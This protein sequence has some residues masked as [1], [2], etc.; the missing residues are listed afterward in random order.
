[1]LC[2]FSSFE[3]FHSCIQQI[4]QS[5]QQSPQ[6]LS[7]LFVFHV[8]ASPEQ[9]AD[10][11]DSSA[12]SRESNCLYGFGIQESKIQVLSDWKTLDDLK[13]DFPTIAADIIEKLWS[14]QNSSGQS[15]FQMLSSLL[16][17]KGRIIINSDCNFT[18]EEDDWP[19]LLS[20]DLGNDVRR[21]STGGEQWMVVTMDSFLRDS[22]QTFNNSTLSDWQLIKQNLPSEGRSYRDILLS[23]LPTPEKPSNPLSTPPNPVTVDWKAKIL[24]GPPI[25]P[26]RK[27]KVYM[28]TKLSAAQLL[29]LPAETAIT[30]EELAYLKS[31][32]QDEKGNRVSSFLY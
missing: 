25:P 7:N 22:C 1:M 10:F 26:V 30:E 3:E 12:P 5:P 29:G 21:H 4:Q 16:L 19:G 8:K 6:L 13:T 17:S 2:A 20:S 23:S 15:C 14:Q 9:P 27:D 18:F 11:D 24:V 31:L 32:L 28:N